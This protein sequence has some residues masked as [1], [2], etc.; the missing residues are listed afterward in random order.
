MSAGLP[1]IRR[2]VLDPT[3]RAVRDL[4]AD[5]DA[6]EGA[7][8]P[9]GSSVTR[10]GQTAAI[11]TENLVTRAK[12]GIYRIYA[13]AQTTTADAAAGTLTVTIGWTDRVGAT[14]DTGL[15]RVLTGTGRDFRDILL[16]VA[17]DTNITFATSAAGGTGFGTAAYA[18]EIRTF[19]VSD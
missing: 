2:P 16:Q 6:L 9:A 12:S 1:Q 15:T 5:V 10:T 13:V 3:E 11:T 18:L 17:A 4:R 19:R 14:T 7:P 8:V